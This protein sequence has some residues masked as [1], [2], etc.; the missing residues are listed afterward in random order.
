MDRGEEVDPDAFC[1][2]YPLV[3]STLIKL[4]QADRFVEEYQHVIPGD[5]DAWPEIG[6]SFAGFDLKMSLGHGAFARVFLAREPM[7]GDRLVAVKIA[8]RGTREADIL[9]RIQHPNIVPIH[10]VQEDSAT[11]FTAVCMPYLGAAT[12]CDVHDRAFSKD[13]R[14]TAARVIL[15]AALD[16]P[17]PVEGYQGEPD[18]LLQSGT[19]IEGIRWIGTK[20]ADALAHMHDRGICHRDLKPSNVLLAPNGDP[21]LLDFNLCADARE[22][23][24]PLGG[25]LLYMSPEQLRA[26]AAPSAV[27]AER[28]LDARSD[29]FSLGVILY[30]LA[31]GQ[32]PFGPISHKQS[33]T[34]VHELFLERQARGA[35]AAHCVNPDVDEA[36]SNLIQRCLAPNP[37][38]RPAS[39][40]EVL[41]ALRPAPRQ[42]WGLAAWIS[43]AAIALAALSLGIA[44]FVAM[45]TRPAD[46]EPPEET[47]A[48]AIREGRDADAVVPLNAMIEADP[49]NHALLFTRAQAFRR[50]GG[51]ES[52]YYQLALQDFLAAD[53]RQ[54]DGRCKAGAGYCLNRLDASTE[55]AVTHYQGAVNAGHANAAV[56]NNLGFSYLKL[57]RFAE[58][59]DSFELALRADRGLQAAYHN[60]AVGAYLRAMRKTDELKPGN[61]KSPIYADLQAGA[62]DIQRALGCGAPNPELL[63]DGARVC[64]LASRVERRWAPMAISYLERAVDAG[65]DVSECADNPMCYASLQTEKGYQALANRPRHGRPLPPTPRL[66]DPLR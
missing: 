28:S 33:S 52:K 6:Q 5:L 49:R 46:R 50:L 44:A 51:A 42:A 24:S 7:V 61:V 47:A 25:T 45:P 12:L 16:L 34:E 48:R 54:A 22:T 57:K 66:V 36:F 41:R 8:M 20:L 39:A 15:D 21:M 43:G 18:A 55:V 37:A 62:T 9:G 40:A 29:L 11:G 3:Q 14:P 59:S 4:V 2:Q 13:L 60:R 38:D 35:P 64:A 32:H 56:H 17:Y 26:M 1:A 31:T 23:S 10:S 30:E 19:Y 65:C 27:E 63:R 58:A 53:A